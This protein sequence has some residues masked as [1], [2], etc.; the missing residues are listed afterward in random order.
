[1]FLLYCVFKLES[2]NSIPVSRPHKADSIYHW[3]SPGEESE[4]ENYMSPSL[5][6][7]VDGFSVSIKW[8]DF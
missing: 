6:Y 2:T 1:M 8:E 3:G 4:L 5:I 7:T